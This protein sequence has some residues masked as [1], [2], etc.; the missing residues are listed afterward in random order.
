M[1][2]I[3]NRHIINAQWLLAQL[4]KDNDD[5]DIER[6]KISYTETSQVLEELET[7]VEW[8]KKRTLYLSST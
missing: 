6:K 5:G 3:L 7:Q 1:D 4:A 2:T 8:I